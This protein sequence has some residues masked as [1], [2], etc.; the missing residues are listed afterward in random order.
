MR[1]VI[2]GLLL[3]VLLAGSFLLLQSIE[4]QRQV[5]PSGPRFPG[6]VS[7]D[8]STI[9][10]AQLDASNPDELY[11]LG[12]EFMRMWRVRE[13]AVVLEHAVL[14][15]SN[16][17]DAWTRLADAY[18]H[19][20]ID[21]ED[22]LGYAIMR[23]MATAG[24]DTSYAAGLGL[25]Y[26][27]RD[28]EGAVDA[29]SQALRAGDTPEVRYHLSLAFFQM[30]RLE[31][32]A[33]QLKPLMRTDAS[34][35]PVVELFVR[36]AVAAGELETAADAARELARMYGEEPFPYVLLAQVEMARGNSAGA[37]E[38]CNNALLLD[39]SSIP[40]IMTRALL[41]ADAHEYEAARVSYEKLLLFDEPVLRSIGQEGIGFVE[42]MGG[43]FDAGMDAMDE[44]IRLAM[45]GGATGR[46]LTL[47]LR[48]VDYLCQLGQA[49]NAENVVERWITGF[50]EVP[51]RIARA[52][53][54]I[55]RGDF[56][57]AATVIEALSR[58]RDWRLWS[59]VMSLDAAEL[60]ALADI[61]QQRQQEALALLTAD[62]TAAAV[63]AGAGARRTFLSGYAE[64]ETGNAEGAAAAFGQVRARLY[65]PEFPYH[66]DPV[67]H[68][69]SMFFM[70]ES[71]LARGNSEAALSSY[72]A[73]VGHWGNAAWDLEAVARARQK[74]E[75]L[76]SMGMPPQG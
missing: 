56:E 52:R 73:F 46:G 31:E 22:A 35:G 23:A 65:G 39:P 33:R 54:Q 41:Y 27:D 75:A 53:I 64:F 6:A 59:R 51:V 14:A 11:D 28:Y 1:T 15:D 4:P 47:S 66:G 12:V 2:Y 9:D 26:L 49:D 13:A 20:L 16:R 36:H 72:Q 17:T 55:L 24:N 30:G 48:L 40:A 5:P 57:S 34:V 29:F 62:S 19:P 10:P 7:P 3:V 70:A 74:V 45:L 67:L 42:F 38:F 21:D 69:Q 68:V 58:D 44:A 43:E 61:G 25:L 60:T 32:C 76:G 8:V 71:E 37:T 18:A 63:N 50:G